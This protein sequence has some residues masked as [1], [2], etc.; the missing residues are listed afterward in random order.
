MNTGFVVTVG[1]FGLVLLV[2]IVLLRERK[3]RREPA[4]PSEAAVETRPSPQEVWQQHVE[5][6]SEL[7]KSE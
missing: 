7:A 3:K 1:L 2:G 6:L 4:R 5:R